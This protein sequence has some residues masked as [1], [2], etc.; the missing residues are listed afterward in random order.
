MD[1]LISLTAFGFYGLA[2]LGVVLHAVKKWYN[3]EIP[4]SVFDYLF[5]VD[6]RG[7]VA[8][9]ATALGGAI[10]AVA[11]GSLTNLSDPVQVVAVVTTAIAIDSAVYPANAGEAKK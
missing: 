11:S 9:V 6:P 10:G 3:K 8:T 1:K 7:T 4:Y 2:L 5:T